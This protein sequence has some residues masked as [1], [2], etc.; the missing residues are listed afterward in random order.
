MAQVVP[1]SHKGWVKRPPKL[2]SVNCEFPAIHLLL[3]AT[4]STLQLLGREF[5]IVCVS[6]LVRA[7]THLNVRGI[8]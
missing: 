1:A 2:V 5:V 3:L 8:Q 6:N 7:C 4:G